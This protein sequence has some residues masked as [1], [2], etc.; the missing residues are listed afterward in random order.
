MAC[1]RLPALALMITGLL[2]VLVPMAKPALSQAKK[3]GSSQHQDPTGLKV[4]DTKG[5]VV[6]LQ[7]GE[8]WYPC[9]DYTV[10]SFFYTDD[11][12]CGGLRI[13]K[14][15]GKIV[16]YWVNLQRVDI[17]KVTVDGAEGEIVTLA[18]DTRPVVLWPWSKKG[19][20][21]QTELGTFSIDLDKVK[22]IEVIR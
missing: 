17:T 12:E 20:A 21:G 16:V 4:T 3:A 1:L 6:T 5:N 22:T 14:G 15:E 9:I 8:G 19:L 11:K 13:R 18:G 2:I 10:Y 7:Y